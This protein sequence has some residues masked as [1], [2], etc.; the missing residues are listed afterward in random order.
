MKRHSY[1]IHRL[2]SKKYTWKGIANRANY[3]KKI[4]INKPGEEIEIIGIT[5]VKVNNEWN[6]TE[7]FE[8]T[9]TTSDTRSART[10]GRHRLQLE[11]VWQQFILDNTRSD[12]RVA[13]LLFLFL[14]CVITRLSERVFLFVLFQNT[15]FK[16]IYYDVCSWVNTP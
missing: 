7:P 3:R 14:Q 9:T 4:I 8:Y 1:A 2:Q 10:D 6:D 5:R 11:P 16:W 15:G 12:A 13:T